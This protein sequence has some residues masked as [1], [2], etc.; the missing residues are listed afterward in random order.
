MK[1]YAGIKKALIF[2]E[3]SGDIRPVPGQTGCGA[4][5]NAL[6]EF[7]AAKEKAARIAGCSS[8]D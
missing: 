6:F 2:E 1:R 5:E 7:L 4:P 8:Y 3:L